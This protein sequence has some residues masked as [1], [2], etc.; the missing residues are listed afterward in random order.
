MVLIDQ[1]A[2]HERVAFQRLRD[3]CRERAVPRQRLLFPLTVELDARAAAVAE[4][5][6]AVLDAVG[7]EVQ[8]FGER[9]FAVTSVP[10]ELRAG[11]D[12]LA[13]LTQLVGELAEVG[14]S[15]ALE[16]RMDAVFATLACHSVVRAGD[17]LAP[18]EVASLLTSLDAVDF[19]GHCPHGRP[20]L[21]RIQVDEIA[22]RFGRG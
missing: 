14:G 9:V 2:A 5:E 4:Q 19:R 1:H 16:E 3:A 12:P 6:T 8:V 17:A 21:L 18:Q 20:V 11:Q 22:R 7:F 15:R 13:V 10:A